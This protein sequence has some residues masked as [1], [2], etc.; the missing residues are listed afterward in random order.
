MNSD[1][2]KTLAEKQELERRLL[3]MAKSKSHL[4]L[5]NRL[6]NS[7]S[8]V[9]GLD[10]LVPRILEILMQ[11]VGGDNIVLIFR[12]DADWLYRDIYGTERLYAESENPEIDQVIASGKA[13]RISRPGM[14][15][16][17]PG[18]KGSIP[19]ENWIYPLSA[20]ERVIAA[21]S[22]EGM[23]LSDESIFD[24][25]RPFFVYA[26]LMLGHEISNYSRLLE[27][28][29]RLQESEVLYRSLFE[30]SP[31]GIVLWSV[32]ELKSLQFNTAAHTLLGYSREEFTVLKA[33]DIHFSGNP[34]EMN[35]FLT[36]L[37]P[38][39][40]ANFEDAHRTKT[41][42]SLAVSIS[43]KML[44]IGGQQMLLAIHRDISVR[45]QAEKNMA[46][47]NFALD[48]IHE[49]VYL[50]DESSRLNYVNEESCHALG[51]SRE[52]FATMSIPEIAPEF[53]PEVWPEHWQKL[54]NQGV[55]NFESWHRHKDGRTFPVEVTANYFEYGDTGYNLALARDITERRRTEEEHLDLEKQILHTQKLESLGV[56]AGGIAHDFNN[57][58]TTIVGN[59]ELALR[60]LRNES[61]ALENLRRIEQAAARA[62]DLAKQMLAYSGKGKFV[63]ENIDLNILLEE[64]LHLL[65]VSISKKSVLRLNPCNPLP[66]VEADATQLRQVIMN[67]VINASEAIGDKSGVIAVTTGCMD[68]DRSYL[69]DVWLDE[70]LTDGLYVY[71]EV[72]DTGCGMDKETLTKLFD[73]FFS[74]KFTGRGLG[75]SAVLGIVRGH[76]G[77]IKV[78][79]EPGKGTTFKIL[80]PA[81]GRP[82]EIFDH[83]SRQDDWQGSGR[84]L[85]VD[86]EETIRGIGAEMLKE[87]GFT[88]LTA[89]DGREALKAFAAYPDIVFVILDLTM[90]HMD[91]EQC[92][93]ELRRLNPDVK[94]I[95]SS[96][97]NEQE[98]TQKFVGKGLAGFVQKPYNLSVLKEAIRQVV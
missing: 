6:L 34:K 1:L 11:T 10:N 42:D 59:A 26:G 75:M 9:S 86:D 40:L 55:L 24:D 80:L 18:G 66:A 88:T 96:G 72:S 2:Q 84:V 77:A 62:A 87:L 91:G 47:M 79:S 22:M 52:E 65:D 56:L 3:K 37:Q 45:K 14:A 53:Q 85:L 23:Q 46:L 38:D 44:V 67:L 58:L 30:Q 71:L 68:C 4:E 5:I 74:T 93:R 32:P 43:L 13:Q 83:E 69:K 73:P 95:M 19:L 20:H 25:L 49:A 97:Y 7:L 17:A 81:S 12:L 16:A 78:Y 39:G 94:V 60:R 64:M 54:K 29:R 51:Y 63:V 48:N 41:G 8:S 28:N 31:D 90:P 33:K 27:A 15:V 36:A 76:K 92:F 57:I 50:V 82:A 70:N 35:A 61:P 98:I 21:V 89:D